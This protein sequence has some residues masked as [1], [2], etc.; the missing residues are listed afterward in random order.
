MKLGAYLKIIRLQK[1]ITIPEL[2]YK[3]TPQS[4]E[5]IIKIEKCYVVDPGFH[6][7]ARICLVIGVN[8]AEL[9]AHYDPATGEIDYTMEDII[10]ESANA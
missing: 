1:N 8:L 2:A 7:I 5:G 9:M 3:A 6:R 10:Q 4:V